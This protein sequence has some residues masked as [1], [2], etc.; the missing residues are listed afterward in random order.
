MGNVN[1]HEQEGVGKAKVALGVFMKGAFFLSSASG[2]GIMCSL[3]HSMSHV[4]Q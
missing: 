2:I 4:G 3:E 1:T